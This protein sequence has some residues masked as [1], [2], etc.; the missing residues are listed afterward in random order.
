MGN[1]MRIGCLH[2]AHSNID[3][4]NAAAKELRLPTAHLTHSTRADL[5]AAAEQAGGLT[6]QIISNTM[7]ALLK[8]C[9]GNDVV[10]LTCS[11]LGSCIEGMPTIT[12]TPVIRVDE[13]LA[14]RAVSLGKR[15]T[16]LCTAAT[17]IDPTS[18]LFLSVAQGKDTKIEIQLVPEAWHLFRSGE[19]DAYLSSIA[20]AADNAFDAGAEVVAF[21]QASMSGAASLVK[22]QQRPLTSPTCGLQAALFAVQTQ[23]FI[24]KKH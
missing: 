2:T 13:A 4:F 16:V 18:N 9:N 3:V 21:A 19:I 8:L 20:Q 24:T 15:V 23:D 6:T 5:L 14:K 12:A 22:N 11:T 7:D 1:Q 10:V 17:T